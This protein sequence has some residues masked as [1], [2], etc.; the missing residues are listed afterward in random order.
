MSDDVDVERARIARESAEAALTTGAER[1]RP[2]DHTWDVL[3]FI[4]TLVLIGVLLWVVVGAMTG[5]GDAQRT[6]AQQQAYETARLK[7]VA[8][9]DAFFCAVR[10][11]LAAAASDP[12]FQSQA[13]AD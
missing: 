5:L 7:V 9:D 2:W 13:S 12:R 11:Y 8:N 1:H 3:R 10:S 4:L 6:I